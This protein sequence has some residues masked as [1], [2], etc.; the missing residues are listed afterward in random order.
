M[1]MRRRGSAASQLIGVIV[2][3]L[4]GLAIG[5]YLL[6]YLGGP[7]FNWLKIPLP[8]IPHTQPGAAVP[9]AAQHQAEKAAP[10]GP[11][12]V[13]TQP[14]HDQPAMPTEPAP[15]EPVVQY[16]PEY[17]GPRR[18]D[19]Y[20]SADLAEA[21]VRANELA[22]GA[23]AGAAA[24][25]PPPALS[26]DSYTAWCDVAEVIALL[27]PD[28]PEKNVSPRRD[29][30]RRLT[31]RIA[32]TENVREI[33]QLT[34]GRLDSPPRPEAGILLVGQVDEIKPSGKLKVLQ[35]SVP[36]GARR[37][38]ILS[39][40][41]SIAGRGDLVLVLGAIVAEPGQNVIGYTGTEPQAV[42]AG[43]IVKLPD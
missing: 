39:P 16:P 6:N 26:A 13:P 11:V 32:T 30:L 2:G 7:S 5:Y 28:E 17:V 10:I 9:E 42:W 19:L 37:T 38:T 21:L 34:P 8:G 35:V 3:G 43:L 25:G 1:N 22:G 14:P 41:G 29:A 23:G 40:R 36:S 27:S 4:M 24:S 20:D 33:A 18:L 31:L 12:G 15:S